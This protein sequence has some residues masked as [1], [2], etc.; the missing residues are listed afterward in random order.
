MS[1]ISWINNLRYDYPLI[2]TFALPA[3]YA[4]SLAWEFTVV[5]YCSIFSICLISVNSP[6]RPSPAK[7]CRQRGITP[8]SG[9]Y[10]NI[11]VSVGSLPARTFGARC[12]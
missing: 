2:A 7:D 8:S 10:I 6:V 9:F 12:T 11:G 5:I 4:K 3:R 1:T